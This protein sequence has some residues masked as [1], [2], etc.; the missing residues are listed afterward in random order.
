MILFKNLPVLLFFSLLIAT[1]AANA[2]DAEIT[3]PAAPTIAASG[4]ILMNYDTG[5]VLA[6]NNADVKLAPASL[7]K[8]MSVYVVF[9]EISNGHLHLDDLVTISQKAWETPGSRMFIEVGNQVKVEDLLKGVII[10]S[11]NDASVA[12]AEHIAGDETTFADMMNQH[13]ERLGM[14]NSHFQDSNGLPIDN[15]Y[16]TARDLAILS[17]ALIKEFPDYYRWFSQKEF[18]FNNIVQ[19]NRNQLLSRDET[20]DG[21]KTGFTD[22]AGYC[23]VASALR[24]DMRLISVVM[25]ASS[26]NA[27]ANENQ[28][29]LNYGFRFFEA[30]KLYQGKTSLAEARV[31]KGDTKNLQLGLAEDL[32]AT[33]PRGHY[34]D[35]KAVIIIDKKITAPVK[36]GTKLGT[37]NVTLKNEVVANKDLIALKSVEQGNIFQRIY[38]SAMMMLE[39]PDGQ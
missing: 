20:V 8:I 9:R 17:Q 33:I 32:Y 29:L 31:W 6:E 13:A 10:Q 21:I 35:L 27:R 7:T 5:K 3:T 19:H 2:E 23:L 12:L 24:N 30:H 38:D 4:Y 28:N 16:T 25:G 22:A 34:N 26:P 18:T 15:H 14:K 1:T 11:G 36:E 37:V 39:K